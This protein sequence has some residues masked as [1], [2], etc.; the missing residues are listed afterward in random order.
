MILRDAAGRESEGGSGEYSS[1]ERRFEELTVYWPRLVALAMRNGA[2][3]HD[4]E[5]VA[6]ETLTRVA[7]AATA[8]SGHPWRYLATVALNFMR[9]S[10][11]QAVRDERLARHAA[12]R[13]ES[14]R[15]EDQV[16]ANILV[17]ECLAILVER[18]P[19]L[20][21]R[22]AI[23]KSVDELTWDEVGE[24]FGVSTSAA[25]SQVRRALVRLRRQLVAA[26]EKDLP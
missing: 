20:T 7:Y 13:P 17:A 15:F 5:D 9:K 8:I 16:I 6:Q 3:Q 11:G 10:A 21:V 2:S 26:D 23:A 25:Q 19:L 1:S 22:M 14:R 24:H 18:E 4:A 12:M